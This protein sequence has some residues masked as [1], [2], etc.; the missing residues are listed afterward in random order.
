MK[1]MN[2]KEV[3]MP[4]I[5][6]FA[7]CIVVALALALTNSL[8]A[9][10]IAENALQSEIEARQ[11]VLAGE[12]YQLISEENGVSVYAVLVNEPPAGASEPIINVSGSDFS[13]SDI[14]GT[15][16]SA[17][18]G[19]S[20]VVSYRVW[21]G[22]AENEEVSSTDISATDVSASDLSASDITATDIS[23]SDV[24]KTD[25]SATDAPASTKYII[26]YVA[27]ASAKGY[28]GDVQVM[29]GV[30]LDLTV[31]GIEILSQSETAGLGANCENPEWLSQFVGQSGTLAVDKDGGE[32]DSITSS[33]ITSRAVAN[34]VNKALAQV[35]EIERRQAQ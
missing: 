8:T 2:F 19:I 24:S 32:I 35:T 11:A 30:N 20:S 26:G 18:T 23:E 12:E 31:A 16:T 22:I 10:I 28:G 14:S 7:I 25:I 17:D 27:V 5:V 21:T 33:T 6:L 13:A 34:A 4:T 9:D 15:D 1:K 29:I 3:G